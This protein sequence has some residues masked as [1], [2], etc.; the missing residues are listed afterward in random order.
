[1]IKLRLLFLILLTFIS[2]CS[3]LIRDPV[4]I[5]VRSESEH[6]ADR[7]AGDQRI[8]HDA[9]VSGVEAL[10]PDK[11]TEIYLYCR[12]GGRAGRAMDALLEAGYTRV[13]NAG[14]IDDAR[15]Q[16]GISQ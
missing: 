2:A 13:I 11:N 3:T 4:W 8:S 15:R 12:S 9:I 7:I 6:A 10:Y 5:D 14:G 16:R 1:M